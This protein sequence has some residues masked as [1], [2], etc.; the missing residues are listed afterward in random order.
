M[1]EDRS[2]LLKELRAY[3]E[4]ILESKQA[5]MPVFQQSSNQTVQMEYVDGQPLTINKYSADGVYTSDY[6][7]FCSNYVHH[8]LQQ[9]GKG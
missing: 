8:I 3:A 4:G 1:V 7:E 5:T 6:K 9:N 2:A